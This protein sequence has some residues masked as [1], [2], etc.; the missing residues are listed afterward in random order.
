M[1]SSPRGGKESEEA[2]HT[3]IHSSIL[4]LAVTQVLIVIIHNFGLGEGQG[5]PTPVS[6][7]AEFHGLYSPQ[8][9]K[10]LDMTEQ[11]IHFTTYTYN[12]TS[13]IN[14]PGW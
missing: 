7:S 1:G 10:E 9:H 2:E 5:L 6:W 8:G 13:L 4:L 12:K 11:L 3:S 14:S